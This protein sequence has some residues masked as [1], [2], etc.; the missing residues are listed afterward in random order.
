MTSAQSP[1]PRG[2]FRLFTFR[3]I[4]VFVHWSWFLIGVLEVQWRKGVYD[5]IVWNILEFLSI[6]VLVT[7]HEFG[8]ALACRSVGGSASRIMLWPLGGVAYVQPPP[9]PGAFLWSIAAGPL[10]NLVLV[11]ITLAGAAGLAILVPEVS[12]DLRQ[13]AGTVVA[14]NVILLVFNLL[15]VYPLDGGQILR[16]LLWFVIGRERSLTVAAGIGL[17]ASVLGGLVVLVLWR[18]V[19]L[20]AIA[21]YA[22]WRS[23]QGLKAARARTALTVT[24][25][26]QRHVCPAC[27]ERPPAQL[28]LRCPQGHVFD[29]SGAEGCCRSCGWVMQVM[30]CVFC[31]TASPVPDWATVGEPDRSR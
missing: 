6:F 17:A 23:W 10:V 27:G 8:H 29:A 12:G 24:A 16:A 13:A 4:D 18:D 21:A 5:S 25:R 14:I 2:A 31:G 28:L 7:L 1:K 22:A 20:A 26:D 9:R 19:W 3:G 15:P 11:P 30:P